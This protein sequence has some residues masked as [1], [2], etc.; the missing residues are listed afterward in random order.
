MKRRQTKMRS[1]AVTMHDVARL[2]GVSQSTV[3]R[4][5][6]KTPSMVPISEETSK[7]VLDAVEYLGYFP[8]LT[9]RSLRLQHSYMIAIM[10]ADIS[11]AFYHSIV[12]TVQDIAR[13]HHYDVLIANTDQIYENEVHFCEAMMRRPVDGVIM[14]PFHLTDE[15]INQLIE[16]TGTTVV[17]LASHLEHPDVDTVSA[18][19]ETATYE[20]VKWLIE[21]KHHTR[22]G[23][24]GVTDVYPP[25]KRRRR[26]YHRAL[27]EAG[28]PI[29]SDYEQ[30]GDFTTESGQSAIHELLSLPTPP[31]AVFVC[32]DLMAIG[33]INTAL[34][35][36]FRIPTDVAI[37]GF[38]NIP[39]ARLIRPNLTTVAQFPVEMG[40]QLATA[41]F[42]RIEGDYEGQKRAFDI[43]LQLIERQST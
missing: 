7:K 13:Q 8:N 22:V 24:I 6:S 11:N 3:S 2:A 12:R 16:R 25:G 35:M 10:I 40:H 42:Q 26:A 39:E 29:R 30:T 38:D 28:V 36:G 14:V 33:A 34:D 32:N 5:L 9:A 18:D 17:A 37:V 19:D 4:V 31:S 20:A 23:F 15:Q 1:P 21:E 41:L 43:P 27:Q